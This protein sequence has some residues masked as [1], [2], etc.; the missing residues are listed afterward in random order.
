MQTNTDKCVGINCLL[1]NTF[2]SFGTSSKFDLK[3]L[4]RDIQRNGYDTT[5]ITLVAVVALLRNKNGDETLFFSK[6][7][8]DAI[9]SWVL[10]AKFPLPLSRTGTVFT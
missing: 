2:G 10:D 3:Y 8:L 1:S 9:L 6:Y 7:V 4:M 5:H